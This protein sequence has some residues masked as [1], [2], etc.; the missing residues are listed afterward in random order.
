MK[1]YLVV[2]VT[3]DDIDELADE[4]MHTRGITGVKQIV[5]DSPFHEVETAR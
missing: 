4:L 2:E 5:L 1:L 3:D